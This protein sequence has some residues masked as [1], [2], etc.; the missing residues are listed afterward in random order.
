M[1]TNN[2]KNTGEIVKI[3]K[4]MKIQTEKYEKHYLLVQ[5]YL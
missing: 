3:S 4:G 5:I 2:E 1:Q